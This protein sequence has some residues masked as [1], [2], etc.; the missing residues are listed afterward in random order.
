MALLTRSRRDALDFLP[1]R[2][3]EPARNIVGDVGIKNF[4]EALADGAWS[5][6]SVA[7]NFPD[8]DEIAVCGRD[9][10]FFSGVQIFGPKCLLHHRNGGFWRNFHEDAASDAFEAAGAERRAS[11]FFTFY[12]GIIFGIKLSYLCPG[13]ITSS[14]L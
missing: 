2:R 14:L 11:E 6:N 5:G 8:A 7:G 9:K 4:V 1:R 3:S 13:T 12:E 10:D